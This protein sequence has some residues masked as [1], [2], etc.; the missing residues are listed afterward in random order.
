MESFLQYL[1]DELK[2]NAKLLRRDL[3]RLGQMMRYRRYT[4]DGVPVLFANSFPK[5]GTHLLTQ[6]LQGFTKIG[7]AVNSGLPALV[8]F[9]GTTGERRSIDEILE[10]IRRLKP[11]DI[12]YGHLHSTGAVTSA[13][14]SDGMATYFILRDPRDVVVSH[15]YY[16][17]EIESNHI[18]HRYYKDGLVDFDE[19]L[20]TSILGRPDFDDLFPNIRERFEPYL[21]WLDQPQVLVLR[22]EDFVMDRESVI[23]QIF[24]HAVEHGFPVEVDYGQAIRSLSAEINP[25]K[26]PTFRSGKV[27][28]WQVKFSPQNRDLFK[29]VAGNLLIQLR[30]ESTLDW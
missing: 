6:V 11:G 24:D 4:L 7:P 30:Y 27:G 5:S 17:T 29:E 22:F 1:R 28:D 13:L 2:A 14:C 12:A 15:V 8:T 19:R 21:G 26:S 10:D 23:K 16:V 20:R 9:D 18:H 3:Q 25:K